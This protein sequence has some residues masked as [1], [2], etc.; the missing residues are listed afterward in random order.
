M[1]TLELVDL[2]FNFSQE[3][4]LPTNF[5]TL[6]ENPCDINLEGTVIY[7]DDIPTCNNGGNINCDDEE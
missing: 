2:G 5:C 6:V 7:C 1:A 3:L 4:T